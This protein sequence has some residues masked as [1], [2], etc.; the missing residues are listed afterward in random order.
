MFNCSGCQLPGSIVSDQKPLTTDFCINNN[1][2]S[3]VFFSLDIPISV[4][5]TTHKRIH[6]GVKEFFSHDSRNTNCV[7]DLLLMMPFFSKF[8]GNM[9]PVHRMFFA[10]PGN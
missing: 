9:K 1:F 8:P 5:H 4:W 10:S 3:S 7:P 6:Y 2:D